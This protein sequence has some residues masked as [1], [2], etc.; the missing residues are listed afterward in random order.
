M[1]VCISVCDV[2]VS[3]CVCVCVSVCVYCVYQC[4]RRSDIIRNTFVLLPIYD[5]Y[6]RLKRAYTDRFGKPGGGFLYSIGG[7]LVFGIFHWR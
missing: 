7:W 4:S 6:P 5:S 2:C 3:V 1:C